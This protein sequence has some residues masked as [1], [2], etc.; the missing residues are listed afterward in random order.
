MQSSKLT[1]SGVTPNWSIAMDRSAAE[2][3]SEFYEILPPD[4]EEPCA[5]DAPTCPCCRKLRPAS[6]MDED[7]C[8]I[9]DECLAP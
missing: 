3:L 8:G 2:M 9:C 5:S 4:R 6:S 7:G 1:I